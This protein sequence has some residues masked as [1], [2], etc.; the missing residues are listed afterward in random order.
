MPTDDY[1][2]AETSR[3]P[4]ERQDL[5]ARMLALSRAVFTGQA[6]DTTGDFLLHKYPYPKQRVFPKKRLPSRLAR[7]DAEAFEFLNGDEQRGQEE[8]GHDDDRGREEDESTPFGRGRSSNVEVVIEV[9]AKMHRPHEEQQFAEAALEPERERYQQQE[10]QQLQHVAMQ[11]EPLQQQKHEAVQ[12]QQQREHHTS[13]ISHD[14]HRHRDYKKPTT[15]ENILV[16]LG[17]CT[18]TVGNG[19]HVFPETTLYRYIPMKG[20]ADMD[21]LMT[22][23]KQETGI[24]DIPDSGGPST[25]TVPSPTGKTMLPTSRHNHGLLIRFR[26]NQRELMYM[27]RLLSISVGS[28]DNGSEMMVLLRA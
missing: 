6:T 22:E 20:G 26:E 24:P 28:A 17:N 18:L 14:T 10:E 2:A 12:Q 1:D 21:A 25:S 3:W 5:L 16:S 13:L 27:P 9:P 4:R 15:V 8:R 23:A 7:V 19:V 11:H